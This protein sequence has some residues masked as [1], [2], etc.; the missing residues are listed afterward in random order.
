MTLEF[1]RQV[2]NACSRVAFRHGEYVRSRLRNVI[3]S[4][5]ESLQLTLAQL[6][7]GEITPKYFEQ[8]LKDEKHKLLEKMSAETVMNPMQI[9]I[10]I[11]SILFE[12][13]K[14]NI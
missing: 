5:R 14:E 8:A 12:L 3:W 9:S 2:A 4:N 7:S 11:T 10:L 6:S 13:A 1:E